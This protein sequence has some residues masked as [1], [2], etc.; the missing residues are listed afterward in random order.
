MKRI[1]LA[2]AGA[3]VVGLPAVGLTA[4]TNTA[5]PTATRGAVS[6]PVSCAQR[7]QAWNNGPG[8]GLTATFDAVSVAGRAGDPK[9]L[10]VALKKARPAIGQAGRNPVPSCA[11]PAGFWSVLLMHLNAAASTGSA[12]SMRAAMKDVPSIEHQ[13]TAELKDFIAD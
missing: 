6:V 10:T 4:C 1:A 3:A 13:L 5:T 12:A 2:L 7:Y 9:E 11:D 8:K